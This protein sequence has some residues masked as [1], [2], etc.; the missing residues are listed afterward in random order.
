MRKPILRVTYQ[1]GRPEI[2]YLFLP[3][4][5]GEKSADSER[6]EPE[7]VLD[8]NANGKLIGIEILDPN[9][10]TMDAINE[11]VRKHGLAP[12]TQKEL[13]PIVAA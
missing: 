12:L 1:D 9:E 10:V 6:I 8:F 2:A 4:E 13:A 5:P 3:R 11:V 7:M